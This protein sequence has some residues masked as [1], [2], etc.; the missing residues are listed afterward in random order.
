M[1]AR[2]IRTADGTLICR[3]SF[4]M[5]YQARTALR[6]K[7]YELRHSPEARTH[8]WRCTNDPNEDR[9]CGEI[10]SRNH[11]DGTME[12][13]LSVSEHTGYQ[14]VAGYRY[15]YPV[16][17]DLIGVGSDG[18]PVLSNA[19]ALARPARTPSKKYAAIDSKL[20]RRPAG[21]T[22]A[23]FDHIELIY[24]PEEVLDAGEELIFTAR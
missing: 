23:D 8:W 18:E 4:M 10:R 16:T 11:A 22:D 1:P 21:V 24:D 3:Y 13:G 20:D 15:I 7:L 14:T 9:I 12:R 6:N 17:G 19:R 2:L 5:A